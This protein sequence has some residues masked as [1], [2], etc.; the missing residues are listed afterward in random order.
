MSNETSVTQP[1]FVITRTFDAPRNLVFDA[2]TKPEHLMHWWGP[3]GLKLRVQELDLRPGGVFLYAM[4]APD[5]KEMWGKFVYREIIRP[6]RLVL[7]NSFSDSNGGITR[8]PMS[9]TWPLEVLNTNT[10]IEQDGKTIHTLRST[11]VNASALEIETFAA[12]FDGMTQGFGGT[13]DQLE[14]Y[15]ASV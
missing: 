13:M 6:E 4:T 10:F 15:L 5:G 3:T 9:A 14:A 1:E 2:W 11:P 12:G 8:H 7:V